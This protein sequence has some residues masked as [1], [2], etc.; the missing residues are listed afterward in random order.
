MLGRKGSEVRAF[1][2]GIYLTQ[3]MQSAVCLKEDYLWKSGNLSLHNPVQYYSE[4]L[5]RIPLTKKHI[6]TGQQ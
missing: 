3:I 1:Y 4:G 5:D 6:Q 2:V